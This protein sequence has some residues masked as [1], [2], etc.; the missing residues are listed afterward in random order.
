MKE[1]A[2]FSNGMSIPHSKTWYQYNL[3]IVV[4]DPSLSSHQSFFSSKSKDSSSFFSTTSKFQIL[5]R[6]EPVWCIVKQLGWSVGGYC[7]MTVVQQKAGN[8]TL[9]FYP[10]S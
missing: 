10:N 9:V 3:E 1:D 6:N 7:P 5:K 2:G 8:N 4:F